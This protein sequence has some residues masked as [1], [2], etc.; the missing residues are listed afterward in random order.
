[1]A[2]EKGRKCSDCHK[3]KTAGP[4][5]ITKLKNENVVKQNTEIILNVWRPK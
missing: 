4:V 1:M 2:L 3:K 5:E